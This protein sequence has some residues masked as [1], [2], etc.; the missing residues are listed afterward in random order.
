MSWDSCIKKK[1]VLN[2]SKNIERTRSLIKQ[3]EARKNFVM[4]QEIK[5]ENAIFLLCDLYEAVVALLHALLYSKGY[6]V[7]NHICLGYYLND[8]LKNRK[9]FDL[10]DK[11]RKIR[12]GNMYYGEEYDFETV[13]EGINELNLL[14]KELTAIINKDLK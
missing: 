8:V 11:N 2:I 6:K 14:Y 13:K 4:N 9:L 3:S 5:K 12:N 10:F 1:E 7:L